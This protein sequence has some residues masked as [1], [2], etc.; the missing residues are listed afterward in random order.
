MWNM[1]L[2]NRGLRLP[3]KCVTPLICGYCPNMD[4]TGNIKSYVLQWYQELISTLRLAVKIGRI[5]II[6]EVSLIS[7]PLVLPQEVHI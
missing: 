7:T 3:P 5:Y 6:L 2:E 4:V 1:S